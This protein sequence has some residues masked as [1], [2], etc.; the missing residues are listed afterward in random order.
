MKKAFFCEV[1]ILKRVVSFLLA[2]LTV[3]CVFSSVSA[4]SE[5]FSAVTAAET[6]TS[7]AKLKYSLKL[8]DGFKNS[9][10]PPLVVNDT[11]IVASG[12]KIY[13]LD[14]KTGKEI[15]S[16]KLFSG[17]GYSTVSPAY[18]AGKIFLQLGTGK[19]QAFDY[20]TLK[21]LW[22][23]TDPLG[24]QAISPITCDGGYI[25]TGFWNGETEN[26]NY[27]CLST[28]D[29]NPKKTTEAKKAKWTRKIKGGFYWAGSAVSGN[30]V[31]V[32]TDD[33]KEGS[34]SAS[35]IL[36]LGKKNGKIVS[37]LKTKG[38]IRSSVV[39]DKKLNAFFVSS[40]AGYVYRFKMNASSGKLSSL[41]SYKSSGSVTSSPTVHNG[42]IYVGCQKESGGE[43]TVIDASKMK[44][45]YSCDMLGYSQSTALIS[46][47]YKDKVYVYMTYNEK[48]GGITVFEDSSGQKT[49]KKTELFKPSSAQAQ[50]CICSVTASD[51]GTLFYK[52]DSGCVFAVEKGATPISSIFE[53]LKT[54]LSKLL[55]LFKG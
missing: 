47:A 36:C 6:P 8:G 53:M 15:A 30:F 2:L 14:A 21:S 50:Y 19:I 44:K 17:L 18:C 37:S 41:K 55:S 54:L 43:F 45:I 48:P 26:A 33:G 49:A 51:D 16:S 11:L 52:N 40:K 13:K 25:Y 20:K 10:T 35:K 23:Y 34:A 1:L 46:T 5:S 39:F 32:G 22:V 28:K 31:V 29:E 7:R 9:P 42:R 24:G 38:D 4:V 3:L 12:E 27:V